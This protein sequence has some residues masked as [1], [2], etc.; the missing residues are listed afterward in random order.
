MRRRLLAIVR[1]DEVCRR[2]ITT[3]GVGT[4]VA[5]SYRAT[6]DVP[7]LFRKWKRSRSRVWADALGLQHVAEFN[8]ELRYF[9]VR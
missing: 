7:A 9:I 8:T 1:D 2:L 5:L 6:V 3:N 4:V